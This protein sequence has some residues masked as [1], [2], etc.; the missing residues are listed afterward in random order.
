VS[1]GHFVEPVGRAVG[2]TI[3][4]VGGG[5][6]TVAGVD[7]AHRMGLKVVVS[8]ANPNAPAMERAD[9]RIIASTYDV[10]ATIAQAMEFHRTTRAID[11]VICV[12]TDVPLT[13]ASVARALGLPGIPLESARLST[14]KLAMKERF[15]A[16]GIA[17]PWFSAIKTPEDLERVAAERGLPL[18]LKPVDSRGARGVLLLREGVDLRAAFCEAERHS[19]T[20]RLI[21]ERFLDG[22][23][24]STESLVMDG[25][26]HTPGFA[27][28]NY[29][30]L[31]RFAPHIIENGGDLPTR[32]DDQT[33]SAICDLIQ[34]ASNSIG[35]R[36]GVI[37]G[38][39]V[40]P[41]EGP[42][43]IELATRL[44]GGYFCTHEIPYN[45]GVDLL[46][47]AIL[48]SLGT[49]VDPDQLVPRLNRPIVQRFWFPK[50]GKVKAIR[51]LEQ[52][53]GHP[54]IVYL[55]IRVR[56]GDIVKAVDSHP[57]RPAL[58]LTTGKTRDHAIALAEEI[59]ANVVIETDAA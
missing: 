57:A 17:I 38:D 2:K 26:A 56:P 12:A 49:N 15:Q 25:V 4:F 21:V 6:E 32:I 23:Q 43:V 53:Q 33:R 41:P 29:E 51:G 55:E 22:P 58:L 47:A 14:D 1:V 8:D 13:V 35:V 19:P 27:D 45:T 9:H 52:Y 5:A 44:S 28:R 59:I 40:L 30:M 16:D 3:L 46:G 50:P 34:R 18:V 11:G 37:K 7:H 48:Q 10:K 20:G 24:I 39:I 36:N 31:E 54:D 42:C